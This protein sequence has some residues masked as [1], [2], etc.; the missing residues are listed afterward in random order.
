[1]KKYYTSF[2]TI[3]TKHASALDKIGEEKEK[4]GSGSEIKML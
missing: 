1:M 2:A 4:N 3:F